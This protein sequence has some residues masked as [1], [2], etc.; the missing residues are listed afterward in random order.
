MTPQGTSLC[1][2]QALSNPDVN[3]QQ[4]RT[5]CW[6]NQ[7]GTHLLESDVGHVWLL[8]GF[9]SKLATRNCL[10]QDCFGYLHCTHMTW[11]IFHDQKL[12][13]GMTL[14]KSAYQHDCSGSLHCTYITW[15]TFAST[16]GIVKL[17]LFLPLIKINMTLS[18]M[19]LKQLCQFAIAPIW[20]CCLLSLNDMNDAKTLKPLIRSIEAWPGSLRLCSIAWTLSCP[21]AWPNVQ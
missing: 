16:D 18:S 21:N 7:W 15:L 17:W 6:W 20:C 14:M 2:I 3:A 11:L 4:Q 5:D 8:H 12:F 19:G 13:S 1:Q 9:H 10:L